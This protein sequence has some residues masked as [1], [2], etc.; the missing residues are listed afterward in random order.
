[1]TVRVKLWVTGLPTPLEAVIVSVVEPAGVAVVL[2]RVAVLSPLSTNVTPVGRVPVSVGAGV[3]NPVVV[4]VKVPDVPT[5]NVVLPALVIA[6]A[7]VT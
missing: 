3:G 2:A 5:V 1:M 7:A 4:T 6:G